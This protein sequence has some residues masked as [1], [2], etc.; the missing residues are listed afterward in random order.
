M[1]EDHKLVREDRRDRSW[2]YGERTR[3]VHLRVVH[4]DGAVDCIC[5]TSAWYFA[6]KKSLGCGC[7]RRSR[8]DGPKVVAGLCYDGRGGYHPSVAERI[9]GKRVAR[10]WLLE[11]RGGSFEDAEF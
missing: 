1:R 6:K 8:R 11:S 5:E 3:R 10:A 2:R 4:P 7:R 9:H